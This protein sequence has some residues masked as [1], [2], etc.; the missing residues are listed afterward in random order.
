MGESLSP[1]REA[2][3]GGGRCGLGVG[4]GLGLG[5]ARY[6]QQQTTVA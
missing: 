3:P 2:E 1:S 4:V 6:L 5:W